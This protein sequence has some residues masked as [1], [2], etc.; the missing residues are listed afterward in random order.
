MRTYRFSL[1]AISLALILFAVN[2]LPGQ[3]VITSG[4]WRDI[5]PT[6]Y[7]EN[8]RGPLRSVYVRNGG[9]G[10]I[11]AGD[12]WAVGGDSTTAPAPLVARYDGF[13][14]VMQTFPSGL[15]N[16][17]NFCTNPGAPGV[18]LCSPNG[19]GSDGWF[20]GSNT[21]GT[22]GISV[23][24][25]GVAATQISLGLTA[26]SVNL[27]SVFMVCHSPQF[28][29]GCPGS[30]SFPS[31]LT[32]A[33]G[34][35]TTAGAIYQFS[36]NPKGGAG[37]TEQTVTG[38]TTTQYNSV[39]M[40]QDAAGNLEGFAAGNGGVVARLNGGTWTAAKINPSANDLLGVFVD[41]GNP[42]DAWAVGRGGQIWHF[43]TGSWASA[44]SPSPTGN[45][46]T[47]IFLT[48]TSEG[49]IVGTHSTILH[50]TTLG[51]SNTWAPPLSTPIYTGTGVGT[52]LFGISFPSG[53]N[54]WAVGTQ[55][56]IIQTSDSNCGSIVPSPCWGGSTSI[57]LSPRL[58]SVFEVGSSDAWVGGNYSTADKSITLLHWD[59][60][61]WHRANAAT[62]SVTTAD[63][64]SIFMLSSGEGWA[65]GGSATTPEALKWDGNSWSGKPITGCGGSLPCEPTSVFMTS[66]GT[67][68]D[69]WAVG[70]GGH[71][72]RYQSGA[73]TSITSPT[74]SDLNSVFINNPGSSTGAGWAVGNGG[75]VLQL[76]IS[77]GIPTWTPYTISVIS[78][79]Q[80][81]YGVYFKDSTHGV[82]VGAQ[83]T[84]AITTD[85]A[86]WSGGASQVTPNTAN[87][88]SVY[89]DTF[90]TGSGNGDGWAVGD[91]GSGSPP[92]VLFAHWNGG[93]WTNTPL[94]T[95]NPPIEG[96][97][98]PTGLTLRSVFLTGPE[99]GFA[100]GDPIY[101]QPGSATSTLA[102]IIHLDPLNIPTSGGG[103]VTTTPSTTTTSSTSASATSTVASSSTSTVS[104]TSLVT[105]STAT[106][107][108]TAASSAVTSTATST[109]STTSQETIV[110]VSSS[111]STPLALP[112]IPGFPWE[113]IIAGMILGM[114][115]L[116]IL[117]RRKK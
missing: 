3:G 36:G 13:S 81:L 89:I 60:V 97:L 39:Y 19:D 23:Y 76:T 85:G 14:W 24:Y 21:A 38:T 53:G 46:L 47:G 7:S 54:G 117:R 4:N 66:S 94:G 100:V 12:G 69:G 107:S 40:F 33:V 57:V 111:A 73:W 27:T 52:D 9:S 32:D 28:G 25:D 70:T 1:I 61:K 78:G 35:N 42:I 87:L 90:G 56:V 72:W 10:S 6:H 75:T 116:A 80:N 2:I 5:N 18:G 20:V 58:N 43:T 62:L 63:I 55:G 26:D 104:S 16:S 84:V 15:Y 48:S 113:S 110:S 59:G 99:D 79:G 86:S 91:D 109:P 101:D 82:I 93:G 41:Q 88:R 71:I 112:P 65:L 64:L 22:L 74:T 34:E 30:I 8:V 98:I 31:G 49:W 92:N 108:T 68:G 17:V 11:G 45:D 51:S 95:P 50:S 114:A 83:A 67:S 103:G 102:G 105:S 44:Y 77:G 37:W 29:S 115:A 96:G 106:S